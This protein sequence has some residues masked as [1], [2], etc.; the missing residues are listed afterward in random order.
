[1]VCDVCVCLQ[2]KEEAELEQAQR[3][4]HDKKHAVHDE[5][6]RKAAAQEVNT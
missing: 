3:V 1:M 2:V 6:L 5:L 4:T